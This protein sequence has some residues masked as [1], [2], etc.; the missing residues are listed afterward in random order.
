MAFTSEAKNAP[1]SKTPN[2]CGYKFPFSKG[3]YY[4]AEVSSAA[5]FCR[6][7]PASQEML[8]PHHCFPASKEMLLVTPTQGVGPLQRV[9][10]ILD[11]F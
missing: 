3:D 8:L 6:I 1:Q 5:L 4:F 11:V 7:I 9:A 10:S 2:S